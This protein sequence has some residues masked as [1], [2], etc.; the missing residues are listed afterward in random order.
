[1]VIN[2]KWLLEATFEGISYNNNS[3]KKRIMLF[4]EPIFLSCRSCIALL[5]STFQPFT[6][7][8]R[9]DAQHAHTQ[10]TTHKRRNK[11]IYRLIIISGYE[12]NERYCKKK[13]QKRI[14]ANTYSNGSVFLSICVCVLLLWFFVP[15]EFYIWYVCGGL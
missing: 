4:F 5:L 2:G 8:E 13:Y 9:A 3:K 15:F 12:C 10:Y 7:H 6:S 11:I 14:W 1:M